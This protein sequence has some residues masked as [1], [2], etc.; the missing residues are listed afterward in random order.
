M[1]QLHETDLEYAVNLHYNSNEAR[2]ISWGI[3]RAKDQTP[4]NAANP[5]KPRQGRRTERTLPLPTNVVRLIAHRSR[6]I[7]IDP[8]STNKHTQIPYR[9]TLRESH[10]RQS[11][12]RD[13][14]IENEYRHTHVVFI[15]PVG[16]DVHQDAAKNVGWRDQ[17]LRGRY[18]E[19]EAL[20]ENDGHEESEG[21]GDCGDHEEDECEAPNLNLLGWAEELPDVEGFGF[22]I[23]SVGVQRVDYPLC[24]FGL[25]ECEGW[26]GGFL[27]R[28]TDDEDVGEEGDRAGYDSF[29]YENPLPAAEAC[30]T[31]HLH[32]TVCKDAA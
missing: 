19:T 22:D 12:K 26:L 9:L 23:C 29:H 10:H 30:C 5:T 1:C 16:C 25:E 32:E 14:C 24:F 11:N 21:V 31:F 3:L 7:R 8:R 28:E 6:Y 4:S 17:A 15:A 18:T 2:N 27:V 20:G 13:T